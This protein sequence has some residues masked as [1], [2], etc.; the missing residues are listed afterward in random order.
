MDSDDDL[1]LEANDDDDDDD[2]DGLQMEDNDAGN[3]DDDDDDDDGLQLEANDGSEDLQLEGNDDIDDDG[4]EDD[5]LQMEAN[6][7]DGGLGHLEADIVDEKPK[8]KE[9]AFSPVIPMQQAAP[10]LLGVRVVISGLLSK[11]ELNGAVGLAKTYDE[12]KGRYGVKVDGSTGN[13][14]ALKPDNLSPAPKLRAENTASSA[15]ADAAKTGSAGGGADG[16]HDSLGALLD[17]IGTQ[18]ERALKLKDEGQPAEAANLLANLMVMARRALG[19]EH[20]ET[21]AIT[22]NLSAML[23]LQGRHAEAAPL[24]EEVVERRRSMLG[25]RDPRTLNAL[26]NHGSLLLQIGETTRAIEVRTEI[27][28]ARE[29]AL[30]RQDPSTLL[31]MD[32]LAMALVTYSIESAPPDEPPELAPLEASVAL[33][34][35]ELKALIALHGKEIKAKVPPETRATGS[36]VF[37]AVMKHPELGIEVKGYNEMVASLQKALM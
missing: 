22:N 10:L 13:L 2:S 33:L 16:S 28:A 7:C 19:H 29:A 24:V 30:G 15:A 17:D 34:N 37:N 14:L 25:R 1:Q 3:E 36:K 12:K 31:A 8:L 23:Q 20:D 5:G 35:E 27:L 26:I 32:N 4:S 11:P 9:S 6:D 21:L 18:H